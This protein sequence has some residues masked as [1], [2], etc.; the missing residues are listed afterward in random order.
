MRSRVLIVSLFLII[1]GLAKAQ[2]IYPIA[3]YS[4]TDKLAELSNFDVKD[5]ILY[6]PLGESGL[7]ILNTSDFD[8]IHEIAVY[9]EHEKR[10]GDK[11]FGTANC[12]KVIENKAY[13]PSIKINHLYKNILLKDKAEG[14][15][16]N[17]E[18]IFSS[19][20]GSE[21]KKT[22]KYLEN[23]LNSAYWIIRCIEQRRKTVLDIT[24][25]IIDYQRDF[26]EKGIAFL[27]P[28]SMRKAADSLGLHESTVSRA[29]NEKKIQLPR[30]LYDMKFF[31]SKALPQRSDDAVSN[32]RIKSMVKKY[33][34][35]EDPYQPYSD[36]KLAD[37]LQKREKIRI[38][39][40]TITKYR[41]L[42][43]IS[44]A[45]IRRRY[46]KQEMI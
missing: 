16:Q 30:G 28:L 9:T 2:Y 41:K 7:H 14:N 12:V 3:E 21:H 34:L 32:E 31:F 13:F 38:A 8:N 19:D 20:K 43:G 27:K 18:T 26:L 23:K 35:L 42:Q 25:F 40:R 10:S 11:V 22:L 29:I 39:R 36:Q 44:S 46:K 24:R 45:K 37:L 15:D 6:L 33:I 1:S 17:R 5:T 4:A